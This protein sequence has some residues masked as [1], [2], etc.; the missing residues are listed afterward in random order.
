M[1][2]H[3]KTYLTSLQVPPP[4]DRFLRVTSPMNS[5]LEK[6]MGTNQEK[7]LVPTQQRLEVVFFTVKKCVS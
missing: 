2:N 7:L 1:Y 3:L 6:R 4:S 5:E